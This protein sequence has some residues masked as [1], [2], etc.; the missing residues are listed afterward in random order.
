[1]YTDCPIKDA[2]SG[3][4]AVKVR[5]IC[6]PATVEDS[7]WKFAPPV[8]K[9]DM[10][11][12]SFL[13]EHGGLYAD[14]DVV[15]KGSFEPFVKG[16]EEKGQEVA[17]TKDSGYRRGGL[18]LSIGVVIAKKESVFFRRL[19]DHFLGRDKLPSGYQS[20]G[21]VLLANLW[22]KL[23]EGVSVANLPGR[24]VYGGFSGREPAMRA[25]WSMSPRAKG[26]ALALHW[27]GGGRWSKRVVNPENLDRLEGTP[28][29]KAI[30][31]G[32]G[33]YFP[34]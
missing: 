1:M 8:T 17:V 5:P 23:V 32:L 7:L 28:L 11:R 9:S 12:W 6:K 29:H 14:T 2:P 33:P 22:G 3:F 13:A 34:S 16:M 30:Q 4:N 24:L 15:F 25:A 10:W 27:F 18:S 31:E 26:G 20:A 19:T 21:V